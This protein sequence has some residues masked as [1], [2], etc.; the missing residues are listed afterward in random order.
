MKTACDECNAIAREILDAFQ[1]TWLSAGQELRDAWA[2]IYKLRGGTEE[3]VLRA[4]ELLRNARGKCSPRIGDAIRKR[5]M[6]EAR[7]GHRV[8]RFYEPLAP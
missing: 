4:E 3:D 7:T 8:P 5:L 1:E 2:A 6:H